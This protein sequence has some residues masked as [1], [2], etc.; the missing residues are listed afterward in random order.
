M[1]GGEWQFEVQT[2]AGVVGACAIRV[3]VARMPKQGA[4]APV[5]VVTA[6]APLGASFQVVC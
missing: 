2:T 5:V 4:G 3:S 1:V 6:A